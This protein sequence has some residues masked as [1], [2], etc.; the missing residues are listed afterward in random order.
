MT[1]LLPTLGVAFAAFCVWLVVRVVNRRERWAKW[2]LAGGVGVPVMYVLSVGPLG[3]MASHGM[4]PEF[5]DDEFI[6]TVYL[7]L[8]WIV[9]EGP[10]PISN[11]L[12]SYEQ[13]WH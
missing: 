8:T 13:L 10:K 4:L 7:P 6:G 2:T 5:V 3:W 11:A 9:F 1:I 12:V